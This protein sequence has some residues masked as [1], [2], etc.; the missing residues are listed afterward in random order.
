MTS[1]MVIVEIENPVPY[2]SGI[3]ISM[4]IRTR[5]QE[6][7]I[8]YIG[9]DINEEQPSYISGQLLHGDLVVYVV[10][11]GKKDK[12]QVLPPTRASA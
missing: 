5:K 4:F 10:F 3:D 1:S 8:F 7:F 2:R 12:F 11:D 9:T 6:G